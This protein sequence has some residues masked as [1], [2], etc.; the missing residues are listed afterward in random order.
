M[1]SRMKIWSS[2]SDT[3][4][5][6]KRKYELLSYLPD[7]LMRQDKM[8]MAHT[9]ENRV[10]FLDNEMLQIALSLPEDQLIKQ[11]NGN[12]EGKF[13]LKEIAAEAFGE[14]FAFRNKMG[15]G[16]PLKAFFS[17]APFQKRWQEELLPGIQRRNIFKTTAL[18]EWMS[19]PQQM[20]AEQ[21]DSV[22]LMMGFEIWAKQYLD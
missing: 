2:I 10:P 17:S 21:L 15:F 1:D 19:V 22:W 3:S 8:S 14:N 12:W 6:R 20:T 9:I 11:R 4:A 7:L 13:I 16:I 18:A 5:K